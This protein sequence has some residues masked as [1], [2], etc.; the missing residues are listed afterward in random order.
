MNNNKKQL[1][2][3]YYFNAKNPGA[4]SSAKKLYR[5]LQKRYPGRYSLTYIRKWLTGVDSYSVLKQVR[6]KFKTPNVRVTFID[7]QFDAD[8]TSVQNIAKENDGI[9]FL[10]FV[11]DIFSRYLWVEPLRNKTA[12]SVLGG[13]KKIF[14]ERKPLK[15]RSDMG[16]EFVNKH[17]KKLMKDNDIY[18]FTTKNQP[19]ANFVE[20]VQRSFKMLMYRYMRKKRSYRYIDV[21]QKLVHNYNNT[22]HRSLNYIAPANVTKKNEADLWAHMYLKTTGK[23]RETATPF[24]FKVGD[25]VRISYLKEPFRRSY[26]QQF[27]TEIF[28]VKQRYRHQGVPVYKLVDWNDQEIKGT[29]YNAELNRVDKNADSLFYIDRVLKR[30]KRNGNEQLFVS[31]EGYPAH[32]NSWIDADQVQ[33][34]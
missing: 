15:F 10:L 30:R 11:I 13:L 16:G 8:L 24:R 34:A 5:V 31:W 27:S 18:F 21:L 29:F 12:Q 3:N 17:V 14:G 4:F 1:L 9:N 32:M 25:Y 2:E 28:K 26:Q 20:R 23:A 7:E 33:S 19:H 22:P 6:R